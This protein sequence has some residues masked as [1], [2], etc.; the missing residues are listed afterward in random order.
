MSYELVRS[1][2]PVVVSFS[3]LEDSKAQA[4][5]A[6]GDIDTYVSQL[7]SKVSKKI[8][9]LSGYDTLGYASAAADAVQKKIKK[10]TDKSARLLAFEGKVGDFI[11]AA[12]DADSSVSKK[13]ASTADA[14]I[15][16]RGF[17]ARI[18]DTMY[19]FFCV[20]LANSNDITRAISDSVRWVT[21][22]AGEKLENLRD[23]FKYG[24][25]R[26]WWDAIKA[27]GITIAAIAAA[28]AAV[29]SMIATC[30]ASSPAAIPVILAVIKGVSAAGLAVINVV[31]TSH[32]LAANY[33]AGMLEK[34]GNPAAARYYREI[35]SFSDHVN[36]TDKG[37]ARDNLVWGAAGVAVDSTE[38]AFEILN[39]AAGTLEAGN[40]YDYREKKTLRAKTGPNGE[41]LYFDKRTAK[42]YD[43]S[44][45][46]L[47][48]NFLHNAG[49][50]YKTVY[51]TVDGNTQKS[52]EFML[53]TGEAFDV[54]SFFKPE[55][56]I[57]NTTKAL[58]AVDN[59][60]EYAKNSDPTLS[61]AKEAIDSVLDLAGFSD[62]YDQGFKP[63]EI[64]DK[65]HGFYKDLTET[66]VIVGS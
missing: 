13:I 66:P 6:R 35:D 14:T 7:S 32:D 15:G 22:K 28:V 43:L 8:N 48:K 9:S 25:G 31:N 18:G 53:D 52:V 3:A 55:K 5:K 16:K 24:E 41:K 1:S 27:I 63:Y 65:V 57:K 56:V 40:V 61:D 49:Y 2:D 37:D 39:F 12:R 30:G 60:G 11:S 42:G 4:K 10:L 26:Y 33:K 17:F 44:I 45:D 47:R 54:K 23:W 46:N 38:T 51:N 64:V 19:N 34:E 21:N 29:T 50:R 20:D 59:L 36:K 58:E 62:F